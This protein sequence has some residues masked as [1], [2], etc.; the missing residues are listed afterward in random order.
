V[1]EIFLD[2][3]GRRNFVY[4]GVPLVGMSMHVAVAPELQKVSPTWF[5]PGW[6]VIHQCMSRPF[7]V[8]I[9]ADLGL[10]LLV[11]LNLLICS[12]IL[13]RYYS[14]LLSLVENGALALVCNW[15]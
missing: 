12:P 14:C 6:T 9:L 1:E 4:A 13:Q 2:K 5:L 3:K 8:E 11:G 15:L 7:H 10:C